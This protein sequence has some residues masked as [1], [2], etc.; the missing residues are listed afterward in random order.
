MAHKQLSITTVV[1]VLA[2]TLPAAAGAEI[3][4]HDAETARA[5]AS[6]WLTDSW[7]G[8]LLLHLLPA[9]LANSL[10][11][12]GTV[13]GPTATDISQGVCVQAPFPPTSTPEK[14]SACDPNG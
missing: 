2:L 1:L 5:D 7:L 9:D 4:R 6:S 10:S 8:S 13:T 12:R 3:E 14:G 11:V